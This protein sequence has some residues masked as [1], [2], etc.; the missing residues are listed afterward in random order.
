MPVRFKKIPATIFQRFHL[1]TP[2]ISSCWDSVLPRSPVAKF[3]VLSASLQPSLAKSAER[4]GI[5][6]HDSSLSLH[7]WIVRRG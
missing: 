3:A 6:P 2:A 1:E 5:T 7:D 4:S